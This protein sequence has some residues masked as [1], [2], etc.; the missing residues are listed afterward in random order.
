M[1]DNLEKLK[2]LTQ[3]HH[4]ISKDIF[5][6]ARVRVVS[7]RTTNM[8]VNVTAPAVFRVLNAINYK[9]IFWINGQSHENIFSQTVILTDE[10]RV[11]LDG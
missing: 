11:T 6:T 9:K 1:A 4:C 10:A 8:I 3:N 7:R 2:E 5:D